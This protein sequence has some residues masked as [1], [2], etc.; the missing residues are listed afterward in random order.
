MVRARSDP[1]ETARNASMWRGP[2]LERGLASPA[3]AAAAAAA[4]ARPARPRG[5]RNGRSEK[6]SE[7][8]RG[9]LLV[10]N[11]DVIF[12]T[13]FFTTFFTPGAR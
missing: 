13:Q 12:F 11:Q 8:L 3:T 7:K 9:K 2:R 5:A 10:T 6:P 4:D 1:G